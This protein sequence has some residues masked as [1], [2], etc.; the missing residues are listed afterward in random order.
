MKFTVITG[1]PIE[2]LDSAKKWISVHSFP[3]ESAISASEYELG[4]L[5]NVIFDDVFLYEVSELY[6]MSFDNNARM[7]DLVFE[8]GAILM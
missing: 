1:R 6:G 7:K 5:R 4:K 3:V 2:W 8:G